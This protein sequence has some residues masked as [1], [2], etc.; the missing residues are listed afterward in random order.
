MTELAGIQA[1]LIKMSGEIGGLKSTVDQIS[2]QWARQETNASAGRAQLHTKIEG[3]QGSV[4]ALSGRVDNLSEKVTAIEPS[5]KAFERE[6]FRQ[7]GVKRLGARLWGA[8]LVAAGFA[9]WGIH[10]TVSW[11]FRGH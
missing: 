6:E 8:M 5:M 1:A 3:V 4:A 2:S 9:G 7:E 10:E 11:W